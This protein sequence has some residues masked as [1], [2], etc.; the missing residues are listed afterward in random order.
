LELAVRAARRRGNR[1]P[2]IDRDGKVLVRRSAATVADVNGE[3][4]RTARRGCAVESPAG[5][6]REAGRHGSRIHRPI[7]IAA[8]TGGLELKR[9]VSPDRSG[10]QRRAVGNLNSAARV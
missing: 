5:V 7:E 6:Q 2:G 10:G 1:R 3:V 4:E 8:A 9:V